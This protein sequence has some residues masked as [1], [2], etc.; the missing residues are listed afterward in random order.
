MVP[1][2]L[3]RIPENDRLNA[4]QQAGRIFQRFLHGDQTENGFAAVDDPVVIGHGQLVHRAHNHLA[5]FHHGAI[6]GGM[7]AEN[8]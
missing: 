3:P 4:K 1:G 6:L 2:P 7:N 8:R 5:V